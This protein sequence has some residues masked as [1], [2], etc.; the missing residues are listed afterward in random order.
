MRRPSAAIGG[1]AFV[2]ADRAEE[3]KQHKWYV[4]SDGYICRAVPANGRQRTVF[5]HTIV[6]QTP[7]GF[8]TDH[9]NRVRHFNWAE[10]LRTATY[11]QNQQN[12]PKGG[13][14]MG[15]R[16]TSVHKGVCWDL[17]KSTWR[18]YIVSNGRKQH[19][20]YFDS[21]TEAACAYNRAALEL[22]GEFALL[23]D[24]EGS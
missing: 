12:K 4:N 6:N 14:L 16:T 19:L 1:Y 21:Q 7:E 17:R 10:N 23:N 24:I 18:A 8:E 20:G 11:N 9:K 2:D 5:M 3:F 15:S 13:T 22:F